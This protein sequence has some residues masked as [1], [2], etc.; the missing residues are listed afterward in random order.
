MMTIRKSLLNKMTMTE[1]RNLIRAMTKMT[2][3]AMKMELMK[4]VMMTMNF[5]RQF[6]PT[7]NTL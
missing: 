2:T 3:E 4:T 1:K 6:V 5:T 7:S